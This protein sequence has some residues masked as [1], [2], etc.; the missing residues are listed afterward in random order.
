MGASTAK[1]CGIRLDR[2]RPV[3]HRLR[4]FAAD[5][6]EI[7]CLGVASVHLHTGD[8]ETHGDVYVCRDV[9]GLLLSRTACKDLRLL[10]PSFP[11]QIPRTVY[12]G[13]RYG[14]VH[15]V[16]ARG[17]VGR[18]EAATHGIVGQEVAVHGVTECKQ[19]ACGTVGREEACL[20]Y[21]SPSPR[22]KRQ[23]RMPSSA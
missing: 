13:M 20:L 10:H 18:E 16:E 23:S 7:G 21:T 12:E 22:D 5:R 14:A 17:I 6:K 3:P 8:A 1:T 19:A 15:H 11:A 2:L 9:A 4:L